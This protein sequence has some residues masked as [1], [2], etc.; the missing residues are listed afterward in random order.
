MTVKRLLPFAASFIVTSA[1]FANFCGWIFQCGCHSLWA[2][3]DAMCNVHVAHGKHCPWCSHG[4][5]GY[6]IV[7]LLVSAPQLA[8]SV[9]A[10][11]SLTA[12]TATAVAMFPI[13]GII[14]ALAFGWYDGYW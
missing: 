1:F 4:T 5:M 13:V 2:G 7:M 6:A 10:P 12:R 9:F 11:W 14:V 3:A 8:V